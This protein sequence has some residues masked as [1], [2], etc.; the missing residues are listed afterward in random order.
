[1]WFF[2]KR[3]S[4]YLFYFSFFE[5]TFCIMDTRIEFTMKYIILSFVLA[6]HG[7]IQ[8]RNKTLIFGLYFCQMQFYTYTSEIY[9]F[10]T[11]DHIHLCLLKPFHK[12]TNLMNSIY[13]IKR[14]VCQYSLILDQSDQ[15]SQP[16]KHIKIDV[17]V[18]FMKSNDENLNLK[19]QN[20]RTKL[21]K[22]EAR[23]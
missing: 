8:R 18:Y 7:I 13:T 11:S 6:R 3:F 22:L 19:S 12:L 20:C 2:C 15:I 17:K 5:L 10:Q 21:K 4:I 14:A 1:M 16:K 9:N 23:M